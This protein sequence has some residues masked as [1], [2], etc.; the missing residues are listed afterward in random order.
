MY[1]RV[2]QGEEEG[3]SGCTCE[4]VH[5]CPA[6]PLSPSCPLLLSLS[7]FLSRVTFTYCNLRTCMY[8]CVCVTV[9]VCVR[10]E[11]EEEDEKFIVYGTVCVYL[12]V[13]LPVCVTGGSNEDR[14][15][16]AQPRAT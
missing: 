5:V 12:M 2:W 4:R 14:Y 11:E 7:L 8:F 1:L 13:C 15:I 16:S 9:Y 6:P 3:E 10:V